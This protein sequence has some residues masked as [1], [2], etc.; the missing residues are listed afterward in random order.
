MNSLLP[1]T[2]EVRKIAKCSNASV[3]GITETK[4]DQS[5]HNEEI[6]NDGYN[7]I[8]KDRNRHGGGVACFIKNNICFN[9]IN[10]F[11]KDIENILFD[12][13]LPK[14]KP[15]TVGVMYCPPGQN[16]FLDLLKEDFD[17]LN[18]EKKELQILGDFNINL[19]INGKSILDKKNNFSDS[20]TLT[21][22]SRHYKEFCSFFSLSQLIGTPTRITCNSS[23]LLDH[24]LTNAPHKITNSGTYETGISD[25]DFIFCT[26]KTQITTYN[27]HNYVYFRCF[28]NYLI[29]NL[30]N[31]LRSLEF[32]DYSNFDSVDNAYSD[33]INRL[34]TAIDSCAPSRK[35]RTK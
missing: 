33:F 2:D 5:I 22:L 20:N 26:S 4:L 18:P 19:L 15:F 25:H 1:K 21:Q 35:K 29:E 13:L 7:L 17:K 24:I 30:E 12:I 32:P 31:K 11:H 16:N 23:T 6:S 3:H 9:E 28:S 27:T 8:R 14:S 10:F 34:I